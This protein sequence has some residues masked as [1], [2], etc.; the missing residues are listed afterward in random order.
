MCVTSQEREKSVPLSCHQTEIAETLN[1]FCFTRVRSREGPAKVN[2]T[3]APSHRESGYL[4]F[5]TRA[6]EAN[7][8]PDAASAST[9]P[10]AARSD[11]HW[12]ANPIDGGP[13][14]RP[15]YPLIVTKASAAPD[16][17]LPRAPAAANTIGTT[18]EHPAPTSRK[19]KI[20]GAG[21]G[22][23]SA[24]AMPAEATALPPRMSSAGPNRRL[25]TSPLSRPIVIAAENT[26]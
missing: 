26:A 7:Q 15:A 23:A 16:A 13:A 24:I 3:R 22:S 11:V 25:R 14:N 4:S 12:A 9:I 5:S 17:G 18:I 21:C 2:A 1:Y 6:L 8:K 20:A 10:K 19:P